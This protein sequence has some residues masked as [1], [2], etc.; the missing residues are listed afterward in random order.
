MEPTHAPAT[1]SCC[2]PPR[3]N[4]DMPAAPAAKVPGRAQPASTEGMRLIPG[5]EFLMGT[6]G[7]YGFPADGEGPAH[8]VVL[9][10]FHIDA[11]CVTN[12]QFNAFANATG[13]KTDSERFGWSFVFHGQLSAAQRKK[14]ARATVLGSAWWCRVEGATWRHPEGPGSNIKQRWDHPVVHVSWNDAVAYAGWAGK[15]LPTEA[16]WEMAARGGLVLKRFPWGDELEPGGRHLMNV[17]QGTFPTRNTAA[18]GHQGTAPVR[19]YKPNGYGLYQVT[20]NVW[21][22]CADWFDP[23]FYRRSPRDNP[24]GPETGDRR[25]MRGGSYLCHASYCNRYRTDARSSNT[26]DSATSNTGFRCV[27]FRCC[28]NLGSSAG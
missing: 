13:Y 7:D 6:D 28:E 23:T 12:E 24:T 14:Y 5:G 11:T 10:P 15:R 8:A 20:G 26:P 25:V 2:A 9:A 19:A 3:G 18:D 22:W 1:R 4:H 17:W 16:E 27:G 21:E